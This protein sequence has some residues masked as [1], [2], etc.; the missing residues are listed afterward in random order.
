M[1]LIAQ[2]IIRG[3]MNKKLKEVARLYARG[4]PFHRHYMYMDFNEAKKRIN[5]DLYINSF[6]TPELTQCPRCKI[7][8]DDPE[9]WCG[10]VAVVRYWDTPDRWRNHFLITH[11]ILRQDGKIDRFTS[12]VFKNQTCWHIPP[13]DPWKND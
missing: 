10:S 13:R 7:Y 11:A 1:L 9:H 12:L 6:T 8:T 3:R 5:E 4:I 2:M